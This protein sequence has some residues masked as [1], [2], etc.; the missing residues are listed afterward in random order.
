M[1]RLRKLVSGHSLMDLMEVRVGDGGVCGLLRL[2]AEV[3]PASD[4]EARKEP[5]RGER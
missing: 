4:D 1:A 2:N 5:D 3:G